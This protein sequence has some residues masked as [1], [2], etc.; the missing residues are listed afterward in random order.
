MQHLVRCRSVEQEGVG[1][2][3]HSD[4]MVTDPD[5]LHMIEMAVT[6]RTWKEPGFVLDQDPRTVLVDTIRHIR[7]LETWMDGQRVFAA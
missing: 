7:V 4:F 6:R 3:L 1:F 2:S 5:P